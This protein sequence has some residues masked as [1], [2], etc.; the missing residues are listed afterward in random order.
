VRRLQG[1]AALRWAVLGCAGLCWAGWGPGHGWQM[2]RA[3]GAWAG[4]EGRINDLPVGWLLGFTVG[5]ALHAA[6]C[7]LECHPPCC[8]GW[9]MTGTR[10]R[11]AMPSGEHEPRLA[12]GPAAAHQQSCAAYPGFTV[13]ERWH[14][15]HTSQGPRAAGTTGSGAPC[16][17]AADLHCLHALAVLLLL[18]QDGA[19]RAAVVCCSGHAGEPL[20]PLQG[21]ARRECQGWRAHGF[22]VPLCEREGHLAAFSCVQV[23]HMP[24]ICTCWT[25]GHHCGPTVRLRRPPGPPDARQP[26]CRSG[27]CPYTHRTATVS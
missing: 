1:W 11:R 24:C 3:L 27:S 8:A 10:C 2:R 17:S 20:H 25:A 13:V 5:D 21:G 7:M 16:S 12:A 22:R 14:C 23:I 26:V 15:S 9:A 18:L 19:V 6:C 4:R